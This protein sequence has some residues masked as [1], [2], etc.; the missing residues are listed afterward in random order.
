MLKNYVVIALRTILKHRVFSFI[1]IFGLAVAMSICMAIIML[2]AD[3]MMVDRH[4]PNSDRIYRVTS[5]PY[6]R[7]RDGIP[8]NEFSTTSLP[9]RD[10]LLNNYTGIEKAVRLMRGF[11]NSW[12]ELEP[13]HNVNIPVSGFFADPEVLEIFDHELLYG[14]PSTALTE[15][16][17]VVLTQKTAEKLF[18][19][20]NPVGES[21]KVGKLGTFKI[22]GIIKE[23]ENRSHIIADAYASMATVKSLVAANILENNLDDWHNWY[24]GWV[25]IMLE[26]GTNF[27]DIQPHLEKISKAHFTN[28]PPPHTDVLKYEL[29]NLLDIVPG[30]LMNNPIGP[31]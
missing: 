24:V 13:N 23:T 10:E 20:E 29:Q 6:N 22:T 19:V 18:K 31:F 30:K 17:S 1:N 21:I 25:Y 5:T 3:Q 9:I 12:M 14:D 27:A 2:V 4:N 15:P 28:L 26:E 16:Y 8:G 7:E 11:G